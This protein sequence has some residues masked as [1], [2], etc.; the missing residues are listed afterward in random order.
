MHR[1]ELVAVRVTQIGEI[2]VACTFQRANSRRVFDRRTASLDSRRMP[3]VY[4]RRVVHRK[5]DCAAIGVCCRRAIDWLG[6]HQHPAIMLVNEPVL[7]IDK[8]GASAD[9]IEQRVIKGL[10]PFDIVGTD[11]NMA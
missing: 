6:H 11:Y 4:L 2:E 10:G 9:G 8:T 1:T 5:T 7:G 3:S